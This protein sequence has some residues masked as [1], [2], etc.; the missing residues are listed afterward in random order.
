MTTTPA[1]TQLLTSKCGPH[2]GVV[3][4]AE[5]GPAKPIIGH[6]GRCHEE[7]DYAMVERPMHEGAR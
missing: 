6:C 4:A 7:F 1:T 2:C 3:S 5:G